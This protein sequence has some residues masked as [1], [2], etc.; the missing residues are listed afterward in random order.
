SEV[1][2]VQIISSIRED[3][4][5]YTLRRSKQYPTSWML[6]DVLRDEVVVATHAFVVR[7]CSPLETGNF[8]PDRESIPEGLVEYMKCEACIPHNPSWIPNPGRIQFFDGQDGTLDDL[9]KSKD[10]TL[11]AGDL[12]KLTFKIIFT[13]GRE[14]WNM[15]FS[16]IQAIRVGQI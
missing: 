6:W 10:P 13:I 11:R 15:Q 4:K 5:S 2:L 7:F 1:P 9:A 3:S 14:M 12:V 8:V 16:P